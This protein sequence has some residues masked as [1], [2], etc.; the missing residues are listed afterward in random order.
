MN[1]SSLSEQEITMQHDAEMIEFAS[2]V[3]AV[4]ANLQGHFQVIQ[5][6]EFLGAVLLGTETESTLKWFYF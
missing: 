4:L 1:F 6:L 2:S 3:S 5:W